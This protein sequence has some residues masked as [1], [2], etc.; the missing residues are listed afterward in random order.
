MNVIPPHT[1]TQILSSHVE[2]LQ[3]QLEAEC[4]AVVAA[5]QGQLQEAASTHSATVAALQV[6][7]CGRVW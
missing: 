2:E 5:V 7:G 3:S 4:E 1:H 6:R